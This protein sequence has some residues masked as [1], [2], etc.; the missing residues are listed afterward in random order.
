[1]QSIAGGLCCFSASASSCSSSPS[2][3][4][5]FSTS[6]KDE[7]KQ[8]KAHNRHGGRQEESCG[9]CKFIY[10]SIFTQISYDNEKK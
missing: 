10:F 5:A 1:M 8:Q 6:I 9:N 2:N 4:F 7:E 3:P